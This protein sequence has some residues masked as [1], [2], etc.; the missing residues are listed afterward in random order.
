V[1]TGE[2]K[3]QIAIVYAGFFI[4][5][6]QI[7]Q[8]TLIINIL[9]KDGTHKWRGSMTSRGSEKR[10]YI[11]KQGADTQFVPDGASTASKGATPPCNC[12]SPFTFQPAAN[13]HPNAP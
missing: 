11:I 4:T 7:A 10:A 6:F 5:I 9:E 8:E 12:P 2:T 1:R 3:L 13:A